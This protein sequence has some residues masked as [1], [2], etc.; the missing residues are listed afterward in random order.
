MAPVSPRFAPRAALAGAAALLVALAY[1]AHARVLVSYPWDWSPDE[2][3]LLDYAR[4]VVDDPAS[5]YPR[6]AVP[7]PSAY[8]PLLPVLMAPVVRLPEPLGAARLLALAWT[9]AGAAAIVELVR[10]RGGLAC[11]AASLALY[12]APFDLSFWHVL[13]RVDGPMITL[14]L[15]AAVALLPREV[16][17]GGDA[18][19]RGRLAAGT[20]LLLAAVLVKP[21]AVLHGA[22]LVLGWLLVDRRSAW[23]LA[24]ATA[25]AGLV[26]FGALQAATG[27]GFLWV[28][29]LWAIHPWVTGLPGVNVRHFAGLAWP[30]LILALATGLAAR[31]ARGRPHRDPAMLLLAGGLAVAPLLGKQGASWNYLLP[32]FAA[33]VVAAGRWASALR[34]WPVAAAALALV[35]AATRPFPLPTLLDEA[36]ARAFY[37]FTQEVERRSG[38]PL[39][40]TRPDLV[41]FLAGQPVEADGGSFLHLA[42][43]RVAGTELVLRR[44]EERRYA[45]VVWTWPLPEAPEW[46]AALLRGYARKGECRLGWYFGAPFPSYLAVRRGLDVRFDPPPG[47]RCAAAS[48]SPSNGATRP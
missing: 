38:G 23:R 24:G 43:G 5:L 13:V 3:L 10:R 30:V 4:R 21:T 2:G 31:A 1:A 44:L 15:W 11:A 27:G 32:L 46:T 25:G 47:T 16:G 40:A 29:R 19:S 41:Y 34:P 35:L 7:F 8:G 28:N 9:A 22:P 45:L 14:W 18:L 6:R 12:L 17:R 26:A 20:A 42:A 37:G 36:T 39:L 48:P 33:T